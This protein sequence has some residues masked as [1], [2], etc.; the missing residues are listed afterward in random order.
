[1]KVIKALT[2]PMDVNTYYAA[3]ENEK[4]GFIVDPGGYDGGLAKKI[5]EDGVSIEYIILTH[6][7]G[8][9]TGGVAAFMREFPDAKLVASKYEKEMLSDSRMNF[10]AYFGEETAAIVPDIYI[11]DGDVLN[12]GG[13]ELKFMHT[14]GHSPGGLCI[15]VGDILFSG[16]TLF[17]ES[18]G[19]TD[20]PGCSFAALEKSIREKL[21][22]LPDST[23]VLPGHMGETK[24][25][26]EKRN[27]PF[28][29][30]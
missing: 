21:F 19:R 17:R 23:R 20:F 16:D 18:I 27:N 5:R 12:V 30:Y 24:I 25:G 2:G 26:F 28:V 9:H 13:L 1:M 10:S 15:L 8:D 6:G 4:K 22:V 3:D 14:P 11:D 7:H 29:R